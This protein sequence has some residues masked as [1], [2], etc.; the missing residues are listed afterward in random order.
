MK[1][2]AKLKARIKTA[3]QKLDCYYHMPVPCGYGT[4]TLDFLCCVKGKFVGIE[5]KAPGKKPTPRQ[6]LCIASINAAGGIAFACDSWDSFM[7]HMQY[8]DLIPDRERFHH[9]PTLRDIVREG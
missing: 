9:P 3:L 1:E 7:M 4:Q 2:E 5:T 8:H 6:K